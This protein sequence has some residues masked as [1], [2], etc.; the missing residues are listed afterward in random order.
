MN[1]G[2]ILYFDPDEPKIE[3]PRPFS[4]SFGK[5]GW[6]ELRK[7]YQERSGFDHTY[8]ITSPW[9]TGKGIADRIKRYISLY[10]ET[11][12]PYPWF[13]KQFWDNYGAILRENID[14]DW[15]EQQEAKG[16]SKKAYPALAK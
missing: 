5:D 6:N 10:P 9:F 14:N 4:A 1:D 11:K 2:D 7:E 3:N 8:G 16:L 12:Y 15:D 13:T